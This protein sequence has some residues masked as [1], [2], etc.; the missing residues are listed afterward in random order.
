M[1]LPGWF[2]RWAERSYARSL[3]VKWG[4]EHR[5]MIV[6]H[7]WDGRFVLQELSFEPPER[8]WHLFQIHPCPE[9]RQFCSCAH[10]LL[11]T[12]AD[13]ESGKA[14]ADTLEPLR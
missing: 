12:G 2:V 13:P 10:K 14:R 5:G 6:G 9:G 4:A 1:K 8:R 7:R 3:R 11:W